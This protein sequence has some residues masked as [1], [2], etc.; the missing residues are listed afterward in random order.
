MQKKID[1]YK[2]LFKLLD[3]DEDGEISIFC[4]DLRKIP[5]KLVQILQPIIFQMK[6]WGNKYKERQFIIECEKLYSVNNLLKKKIN[7]EEK[8]SFLSLINSNSKRSK[9]LKENCFS[10]Q[11]KKL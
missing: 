11:V 5:S 3:F 6:E 7:F 10:F 1:L 8:K 9:S 2:K 4:I